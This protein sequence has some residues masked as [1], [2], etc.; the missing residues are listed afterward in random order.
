MELC[1]HPRSSLVLPTYAFLTD[2]K[3]PPLLAANMRLYYG[4][5]L[6]QGQWF[7]EA[8]EQLGGLKPAKVVAPAELLF[9]QAVTYHRLLNKEEGLKVINELLDG[10]DFSPR[11]YVAIA[12]LMQADLGSLEEE[13]LDHIARRME[14]IE[15]RLRLSRAGQKVKKVEDGVVESLDK[16]IKKIED[17]QNQQNQ[18]QNQPNGIRSVQPAQQSTPAGANAPGD[19]TKKDIGHKS[20]WGDLPPKEREEALQQMGRDFPRTIATPSKSTSAS[21][22]PSPPAMTTIDRQGTR[23]TMHGF[24]SLMVFSALA[25]APQFNVQLVDGTRVSGS[26]DRWDAAQLVVTGSA[27]RTVLDV[28]KLAAI[29]PQKPPASPA[30]K[31]AVRVD[32]VNGSQLAAADYTAENGRAKIVF[33]ASEALELPTAEIDAV[34]FQ[35]DSEATAAEWSRIR[36]QKIR[37]DVLVTGTSSAIDYHQGAIEDVSGDQGPLH[38]RRPGP[39]RR[40]GED[41]RPDL[42]PRRGGQCP[43]AH[44]YDRRFGRDRDWA[45]ASPKLDEK[46]R[47]NSPRPAAAPRRGIDSV[48]KIDLSSGR[49]RPT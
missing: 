32:L 25:A 16:M 36:G 3:T 48:A 2:S 7:E 11:R 40:A 31:P 33:S 29:T 6:V 1:S 19:V 4:R 27:G 49:D 34:R 42:F 38:P 43:R 22:P 30:V 18:N 10:A 21:W 9:Y 41:L 47:S 37:A 39:G 14:D 15:R 23:S 17:Q 44:L 35:P 20:G 45:A 28:G 46:T 12:Y 24:L 13:T 8:L 26:L 5:W